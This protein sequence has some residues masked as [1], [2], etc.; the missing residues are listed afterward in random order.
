MRRGLSVSLALK[1]DRVEQCLRTQTIKQ[2]QSRKAAADL[3]DAGQHGLVGQL[4]DRIVQG[5]AALRVAVVLHPHSFL[6][7]LQG[8]AAG[9][10][11]RQA[12]RQIT[13]RNA[14]LKDISLLRIFQLSRI[15]LHSYQ[16]VQ[17]VCVCVC[18]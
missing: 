9:C 3:Q 8:A 14:G 5:K 11:L 4:S 1:D 7:D 6:E 2:T 13:G 12:R 17:F 10:V 16:S 15:V 18:V